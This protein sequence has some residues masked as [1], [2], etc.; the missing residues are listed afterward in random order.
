MQRCGQGIVA[1]RLQDQGLPTADLDWSF[2]QPHQPWM[3]Q[4]GQHAGLAGK[5]R[6]GGVI[7]RDLQHAVFILTQVGYQESDGG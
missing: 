1:G 4:G 7:H 3:V 2:H 5:P 6:R